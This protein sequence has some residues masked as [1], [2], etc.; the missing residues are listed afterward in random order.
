MTRRHHPRQA[1]PTT[2]WPNSNSNLPTDSSRTANRQSKRYPLTNRQPASDQPIELANHSFQRHEAPR[3]KQLDFTDAQKFCVFQSGGSWLGLPALRI[4]QVAE[5]PSLTPVPNSDPILK[6][7]CYRQNEFIPVVCMRA[8]MHI[9]Y[10]SPRSSEQQLLLLTG[11]HASWALLI[12]RV[13]ALADLET[14]ISTFSIHDDQWS[15]VTV[16]SASFRDQV[17]QVLDADALFDYASHLLYMFWENSDPTE[18]HSLPTSSR[19]GTN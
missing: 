14:T 9:Q 16:G 8:L 2:G 7:I 13:I 15:R 1:R 3:M 5:T 19:I 6:G 10:D 12:D 18:L 4:R 11:N 17:L